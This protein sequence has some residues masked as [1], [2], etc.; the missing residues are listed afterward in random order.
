MV[1]ILDELRVVAADD[2]AQH[3]DTGMQETDRVGDRTPGVCAGGVGR[4]EPPA[5]RA[6]LCPVVHDRDDVPDD[7]GIGQVQ[8]DER[9][10]AF[11]VAGV[12][13]D[14]DD[15]AAVLGVRAAGECAPDDLVV[16]RDVVEHAVEGD[17][18]S[19]AAAGGDEVGEGV[20]RTQPGIDR[21]VVQR[22]VPVGRG[23]ED[24][25]EQEAVGSERH[26]VIEPVLELCQPGD[27][28]RSGVGEGPLGACEPERVDVPPDHV[29]RPGRGHVRL[30]RHSQPRTDQGRA[31]RIFA[32]CPDPTPAP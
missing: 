13:V 28:I 12:A 8:L 22:V 7:C 5:V 26:R 9:L 3:P 17:P 16:T 18:D 6:H 32:W 23:P 21:E 1:S 2:L 11:E 31:H 25:A 19:L 10:V 24:R 27:W 20:R 4:V 30:L 29:C 14:P 15:P